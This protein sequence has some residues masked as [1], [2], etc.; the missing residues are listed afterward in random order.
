MVDV[1]QTWIRSVID[2]QTERLAKGK[3]RKIRFKKDGSIS[4]TQ[5]P[6]IHMA[7]EL[8][9]VISSRKNETS[10]DVAIMRARA[11]SDNSH[12]SNYK[13]SIKSLQEVVDLESEM[14]ESLATHESEKVRDSETVNRILDELNEKIAEKLEISGSTTNASAKG[15]SLSEIR[16]LNVAFRVESSKLL[17]IS[18]R[19]QTDIIISLDEIVKPRFEM[20]GGFHMEDNPF[21][22][23][24]CF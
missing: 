6:K 24:D 12:I 3:E 11:V 1:R 15:K 10:R 16:D 20:S 14:N 23:G 19:V 8:S 4:S 2:E 5:P 17:T 7:S 18:G 13:K 9:H 22:F 21:C